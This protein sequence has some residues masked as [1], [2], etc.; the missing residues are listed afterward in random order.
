MKTLEIDVIK[1]YAGA[2]KGFED[3]TKWNAWLRRC[4][5]TKNLNE[6]VNVRKG[7]QIGMHTA[8]RKKLT[9]DAL[10]IAFSRWIGSIEKTM[11]KIVK[12]VDSLHNDKVSRAL[13]DN[14][15]ALG[16]KRDRDA[17]FEKWLRG[18]SY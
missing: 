5:K 8:E 18:Q 17:A 2:I 15:K 4:E 14:M 12:D 7:L 13:K 1:L 11:R 6:L 3:H 9:S 10:A 16:E